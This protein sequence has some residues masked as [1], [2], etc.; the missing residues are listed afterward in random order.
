MNT[1]P[2]FTVY[3][4]IDLRGG[5]VVRLQEGDPARQTAYGSDPAA[6]ARRW[7]AAG[8]EWLHVVNLDGAFEQP[9]AAKTG[10]PASHS[11]RAA[12]EFGAQVQF[13][14]GLRSLEAL[15]AA[16]AMGVTRAVSRHGRGRSSPNW[17]SEALHRWGPSASPPGWMPATGWC[18]CAAGSKPRRILAPATGPRSA[19]PPGCAGWS[20]P[21]SPATG[22]KPA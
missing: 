15:E 19:L 18:G 11:D 12:A 13:G 9:D 7:L 5:Q 4:A 6:A 14:G 1:P 10:R 8:A 3:P 2:A 20:S 22:C 21:I 17:L 16:F